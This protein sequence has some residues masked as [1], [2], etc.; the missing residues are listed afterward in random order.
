METETEEGKRG[1]GGE[2][3]GARGPSAQP[4]QGGGKKGLTLGDPG[5]EG[6]GADQE[7]QVGGRID[8]WQENRAVGPR[9][10]EAWVT[11]AL[12]G[13][14]AP[15][16]GEQAPEPLHTLSSVS[17]CRR[18]RG[19]RAPPRWGGLARSRPH[20]VSDIVA[21]PKVPFMPPPSK[22]G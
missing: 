19:D 5:Y 12:E 21:Q 16:P 15:R 4:S 1:G 8:L 22:A 17:S 7:E 3:R 10:R 20:L 18:W 11:E 6:G 14:L 9:A 13:T 2:Q